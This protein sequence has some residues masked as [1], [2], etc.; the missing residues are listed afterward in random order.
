MQHRIFD[1]SACTHMKATL[2]VLHIV[3]LS[4]LPFY[5]WRRERQLPGLFWPA[6]VVKIFAGIALGLLYWYYY[7]GGDTIN[8][9]R[10]SVLMA[11]LAR[12]DFMGYLNFLWTS[13]AENLTLST[14]NAP[15]ALFFTKIVSIFSLITSDNYWLIALYLAFSAC[16]GPWGLLKGPSRH[17]RVAVLP[18]VVAFLFFPSVPFWSSGVIKESPARA[19]FYFLSEL[20]WQAWFHEK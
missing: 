1:H 6:L 8:Y 9:F 19:A 18:A 7:R 2:I 4:G 12:T 20:F 16:V 15:R 11:D 3:L 5:W 10:E 14:D 13:N 17:V